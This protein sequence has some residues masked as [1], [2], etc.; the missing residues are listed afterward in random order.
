M[1]APVKLDP[2]ARRAYAMPIAEL[3]AGAVYI[4]NGGETVIVRSD[5]G[6]DEVLPGGH[7]RGGIASDPTAT[8]GERP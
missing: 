6:L 5:G 2:R 4:G 7:P 1:T 8:R 3:P